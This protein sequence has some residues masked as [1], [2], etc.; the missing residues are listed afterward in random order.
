MSTGGGVISGGG[1]VVSTGGVVVSVFGGV[2][3][4]LGGVITVVPPVVGVVVVVPPVVVVVPP[5]VGIVP[6]I[7]PVAP[8][9]VPV[10]PP[11]I[12]A[13]S[14]AASPPTACT[15]A[16]FI[17]LAP[18]IAFCFAIS[19]ISRAVNCPTLLV[20]VLFCAAIRAALSSWL[21]T[22][23][24]S[25]SSRSVGV[26]LETSNVSGV[27]VTSTPGNVPSSPAALPPAEVNSI[28]L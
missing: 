7:V 23:L 8:P 11:V 9:V 3:V 13:V 1:V 19:R 12:G 22:L 28:F 4:S 25:N 21:I 27:A 14:S 2:V 18:F 5:V 10:V 24:L 16:I 17:S 26:N 15:A 6:S 20:A